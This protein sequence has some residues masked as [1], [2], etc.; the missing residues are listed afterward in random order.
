M[1]V[2]SNTLYTDAWNEI[3]AVINGSVTDPLNR[4]KKWIMSA[5]PD[6]GARDFPG[7]P[8]ITI[9]SLAATSNLLTFGKMKQNEISSDIKIY[10]KMMSHIDSISSDVQ[11]QLKINAGSLEMAGLYNLNFRSDKASTVILNKDKVH[12]KNLI[13]I[14]DY[15]HL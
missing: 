5:F 7:Y 10:A 4:G 12:I 14:F 1:T 3:Y 2:N 11:N 6:Y 9:S 8:I 15:V 13:V